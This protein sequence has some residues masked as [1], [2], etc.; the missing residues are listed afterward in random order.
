MPL[1]TSQCRKVES[2]L[3]AAFSR[4]ELQQLVRVSTDVDYDHI[5]KQDALRFEVFRLVRWAN[6]H[7]LVRRLLDSAASQ[8]PGNAE[9]RQLMS[10][11]SDWDFAPRF[12][13]ESSEPPDSQL[14]EA[15]DF[16]D[17][18]RE[19][20][21]DDAV[22]FNDAQMPQEEGIRGNE[23]AGIL[24][25]LQETEV[26]G[27]VIGG[28]LQA[29]KT[30]LGRRVLH[31]EEVEK[32]FGGL[33]FEV[34]LFP[35]LA[36]LPDLLKLILERYEYRFSGVTEYVHYI[37]LH[38]L[39]YTLKA[40]VG[41]KQ[42]ILLL[43]N[44]LQE[45]LPHI[46]A[47]LDLIEP[48]SVIVTTPQPV[49]VHRCEALGLK[50][51][52]LSALTDNEAIE[53][54][55]TELRIDVAHALTAEQKVSLLRVARILGNHAGLLK[56][57]ARHLRSMRVEL[58]HMSEELDRI[59]PQLSAMNVSGKKARLVQA[60]A[61]RLTDQQVDILASL[62]VYA[63]AP[64][65]FA[66]AEESAGSVDLALLPSGVVSI[67][68]VP[69]GRYLID[70]SFQEAAKQLVDLQVL[71]AAQERHARRFARVAHAAYVQC[72]AGDYGYEAFREDWANISIGWQWVLDHSTRELGVR[73]SQELLMQ[74]AESIPYFDPFAHDPQVT[75][76]RLQAALTAPAYDH[77][78]A[79]FAHL[80]ISLAQ[81]YVELYQ[82][83]KARE[84][85]NVLAKYFF[86]DSIER[87][88]I[89]LAS[90][91]LHSLSARRDIDVSEEVRKAI[92]EVYNPKLARAWYMAAEQMAQKYQ[93]PF[94]EY[95]ALWGRAR[96]HAAQCDVYATINFHTEA[97]R[98]ALVCSDKLSQLK[99][100]R[101]LGSS[102][103]RLANRQSS[104]LSM[105]DRR[106]LLRIAHKCEVFSNSNGL[107]NEIV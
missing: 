82:V 100:V 107:I 90:A 88:A 89:L 67:V 57:A 38:A 22:T 83:A 44:V 105:A 24:R 41:T 85:L 66:L 102:A 49:V 52:E 63:P 5:V 26:R 55:C 84:Q 15:L 8:N 74:Y 10:E 98:R 61:A 53:L 19:L 13:P 99:I 60:I 91:D 6:R 16:L 40:L 17:Y 32:R 80:W 9:L 21:T 3:L 81:S 43:R 20:A 35:E 75:S 18:L 1:T 68:A 73:D 59:V 58:V 37:P 34:E 23:I 77:D 31:H 30:V 14:S 62:A 64:A 45:H 2:A 104:A 87:C 103:E 78:Q 50:S 54:L 106:H 86:D 69:N 11:S 79:P 93:Q 76:S 42:C 39:A 95:R 71:A 97:L 7:G 36:S 28:Y 33:R 65:T 70:R 96:I 27:V 46:A 92:D 4:T 56:M 47:L 101:T 72:R 25:A 94:Y 51:L 48:L 12:S 29:G